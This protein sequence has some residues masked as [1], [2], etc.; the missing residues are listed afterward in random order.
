M[1]QSLLLHKVGL[2]ANSIC[3]SWRMV[4]CH[5]AKLELC[6]AALHTLFGYV[7]KTDQRDV[8]IVQQ[9]K[10]CMQSELLKLR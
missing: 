3:Q 7:L 10:H 8:S 4:V 1:Y 6:L 9:D 5:E 2:M